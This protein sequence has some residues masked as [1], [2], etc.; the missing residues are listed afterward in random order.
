MMLILHAMYEISQMPY[1]DNV[2]ADQTVHQHSFMWELHC[3]LINQWDPTL[4]ARRAFTSQTLWMCRLFSSYTACILHITKHEQ[5]KICSIKDGR[6][7]F[8]ENWHM[9]MFYFHTGQDEPPKMP[10]GLS[11]L[12]TSIGKLLHCLATQNHNCLAARHLVA[13]HINDFWLLDNSLWEWL[14]AMQIRDFCIC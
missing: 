8:F 3:L 12:M 11:C 6:S 1:D 14:H 13:M 9:L 4:L 2:A 5:S 7:M 10:L